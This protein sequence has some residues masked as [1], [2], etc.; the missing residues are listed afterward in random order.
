M[1]RHSLTAAFAFALAA[2]AWAQGKDGGAQDGLTP[3][4]V[5]PMGRF[6]ATAR[7]QTQL[8]TGTF[9]AFAGTVSED[10][11]LRTFAVQFEAAVGIGYGFEL[12]ASLP[13][14]FTLETEVDATGLDITEESKGIGD[15]NLGANYM[16]LPDSASGPQLMVGAFMVLPTGDDTPSV[17][18]VQSTIPALN[19]A[20]EEG[21][22]GEGA[23][24][25]GFLA[26]ISK[27]ME[28]LEP[29]LLFR[30]RLGGSNEEDNIDTDYAD[31]GSVLLGLEI[32]S[33]EQVTLDVRAVLDF[34]SKEVEEDTTGAKSTEEAY[35]QYG[36]E[37]RLYA[38]LGSQFSL[39]IGLGFR[40]LE[41]HAIDE[42]A[43]L[44]IED[45]F[46]Y[47]AEIGLHIVLGR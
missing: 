23:F 30:Y 36:L 1:L 29:Y 38:S 39:V 42:E 47:G 20:G 5:L 16:I 11:E 3:T 37:G 26:G 40:A 35:V 6:T 28:N 19:Q 4:D 15:M 7:L 21:G 44:N 45:T 18:E 34:Y 22:I 10:I 14:A 43:D 9:D 32:H 24:T 41:D 46:V 25:F 17:A 13:Y 8:G 27:R 33:G 12:E 31:V 2:S